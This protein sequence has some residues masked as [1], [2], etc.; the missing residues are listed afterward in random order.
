[1]INYKLLNF[2]E[3]DDRWGKLVALEEQKEIPNNIKNHL[4]LIPDIKSIINVIND[5]PPYVSNE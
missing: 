1:M 4:Y 2:K 5:L 3:H